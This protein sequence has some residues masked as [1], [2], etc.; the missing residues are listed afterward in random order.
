MNEINVPTQQNSHKESKRNSRKQQPLAPPKSILK[1]PKLEYNHLHNKANDKHQKIVIFDPTPNVIE[2][3]SFKKYN[4]IAL[5]Y[6]LK[7]PCLKCLIF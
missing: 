1:L 3:R 5:E 6:E 7:E 4:P 2:V